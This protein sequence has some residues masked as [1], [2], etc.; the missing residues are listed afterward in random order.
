ML[1]GIV[2]DT[3]GRVDAMAAGLEALRTVG[4]GVFVHCGDVG[5]RDVLDVLAGERAWFV[6]GNTD[7]DRGALER[8]AATIGVRCLGVFGELEGWE[9][10]IAVMHGDDASLTRRVLDE[11]EYDY[12]LVGHTHVRADQRVGRTRIV[13]PGALFRTPLK[14]VA[15]LDPQADRLEFLAITA[16]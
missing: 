2:S 8:Y 1:L 9:K 12:L 15:L 7:W 14:T 6:F 3:H 11:Q 16:M 10:R 4:A 5:G 13:N